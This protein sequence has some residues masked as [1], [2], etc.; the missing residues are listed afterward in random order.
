MV[1]HGAIP[2]LCHRIFGKLARRDEYELGPTGPRGSHANFVIHHSRERP[3]LEHYTR[4]GLHT[5]RIEY[6]A[7]G[8]VNQT[9]SF[10]R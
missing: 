6:L 10:D 7:C 8:Y 1:I 2:A 3:G 4:A 9:N 5:N